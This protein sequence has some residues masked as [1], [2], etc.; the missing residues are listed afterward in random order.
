M[1]SGLLAGSN[2]PIGWRKK[3]SKNNRL[4]YYTTIDKKR[5]AGPGIIYT[6]D[7]NPGAA[8][9]PVGFRNSGGRR[10]LLTISGR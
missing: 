6:K 1:M 8:V 10:S 3:L 5:Q 4:F 7:T 9:G 2:G